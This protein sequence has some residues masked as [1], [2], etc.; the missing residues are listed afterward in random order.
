MVLGNPFRSTTKWRHRS[1]TTELKEE[2]QN[3]SSHILPQTAQHQQA[4]I[5]TTPPSPPD[6]SIIKKKKKMIKPVPFNSDTLLNGIGDYIFQSPLGGGKF[7]K[8]MLAT[9]YLRGEKVAIKVGSY[10]NKEEALFTY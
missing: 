10:I 5:V 4:S 3:D 2:E 9:H 6:S 8:V 1:T 7:S